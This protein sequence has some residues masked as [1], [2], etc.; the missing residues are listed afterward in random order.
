MTKHSDL[1]EKKDDPTIDEGILAKVEEIYRER[2]EERWEQLKDDVEERFLKKVMEHRT[3][4]EALFNEERE[5]MEEAYQNTLSKMK[6]DI[7]KEED[8]SSKPS[9]ETVGSPPDGETVA[10]PPDGET[11]ASPPD[12]E[13]I[14]IEEHEKI[15]KNQHEEWES[16]YSSRLENDLEM[17]KERKNAEWE[18]RVSDLESVRDQMQEEKEQLNE[19]LRGKDEVLSELQ[20]ELMEMMEQGEGSEDFDREVEAIKKIKEETDSVLKRE[21]KALEQKEKVMIVEKTYL[22]NRISELEEE[23]RRKNEI[24]A[25]IIN[26]G[27]ADGDEGDDDHADGD[28]GDDDHADGDEGDEDH[29]EGDEGDDGHAEGDEGDEDHAEGDEEDEDHA[30]GDEGDDDHA[31]GD[32]GDDGH[33]EGDEGDDGHAE[34][35]EGD[36]GHADGDA[37]DEEKSEG[38]AE[39]PPAVSSDD[40]PDDGDESERM[41]D[42]LSEI[43]VDMPGTSG[44]SD[45]PKTPG[46]DMEDALGDGSVADGPDTA[47]EDVEEEEPSE[48]EGSEESV[49]V[50]SLI[51]DASLAYE[52]EDFQEALEILNTIQQTDPENIYVHIM[53]GKIAYFKKEYEVARDAFNR[54]LEIDPTNPKA[55]LN[56]KKLKVH[57]KN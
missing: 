55:Q 54:A 22:K 44:D 23:L 31:E 24:L 34:G 18:K 3:L 33:A 47:S 36:D 37:G 19:E 11:V 1:K 51:R 48:V 14:S 28:E 15:V 12:G 13:T 17:W 25:K 40:S 27:H 29:A 41:D 7:S 43:P 4:L 32:E 38:D 39:E 56:L 45:L 2:F 46:E 42:D 52:K 35:D 21:R 30:E 6:E 49:D 50:A 57:L 10:S 53:K 16:V 9:G 8:Q 20:N 5:D 26:E